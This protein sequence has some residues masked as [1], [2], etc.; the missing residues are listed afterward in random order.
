MY[1][2]VFDKMFYLDEELDFRVPRTSRSF[3]GDNEVKIIKTIFRGENSLV[4]IASCNGRDCYL[5]ECYPLGLVQ[6]SPLTRNPLTEE[7]SSTII[8]EK[9]YEK[10]NIELEI[11]KNAN[12][13][14]DNVP[15][16]LREMDEPQLLVDILTNQRINN[17]LSKSV[18]E[19]FDLL[20]K[21]LDALE[22]IHS[23]NYIQ[24]CLSPHNII[25]TNNKVEFLDYSHSFLANDI[26]NRIKPRRT[27]YIPMELLVDKQKSR[28]NLGSDLYSVGAILFEILFQEKFSMTTHFA[29]IYQKETV[30]DVLDSPY[31]E[32]LERTKIQEIK[33]FLYKLLRTRFENVESCKIELKKL[34]I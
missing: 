13:Y 16:I 29:R 17:S 12:L 19:I 7:L 15:Y 34:Y 22:I 18:N 30:F 21:I 9:Y 4:Y 20:M 6:K 23:K 10:Q 14:F 3:L 27:C 32:D 25:L 5:K 33:N 8:M 31:F 1:N 11:E 28:I 2:D 24:G 26:E